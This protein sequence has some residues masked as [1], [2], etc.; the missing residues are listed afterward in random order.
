[1][2]TLNLAYIAELAFKYA[3]KFL[4]SG[5]MVFF[6]ALIV[7]MMV[8]FVAS[9]TVLFNLINTFIDTMSSSSGDNISKMFGLMDCIGLTDAFNNMKALLISSVLFLLYRILFSQ[10]IRTY[11]LIIQAIK[12]LI[13]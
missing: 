11:Y 3:R 8:S 7:A 10:F 2:P 13:N 12:P 1:M 4:Y 9:F 6:I 5:A